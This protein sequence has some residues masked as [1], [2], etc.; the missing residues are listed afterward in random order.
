MSKSPEPIRSHIEQLSTFVTRA[1]QLPKRAC[2]KFLASYEGGFTLE[3]GEGKPT[4]L[5]NLVKPDEETFRSY[6]LDFR[7]F[8]SNKEDIFVHLIIKIAINRARHIAFRTQLIEMKEQWNEAKG[9]LH[10]AGRKN[11]DG[12][13]TEYNGEDLFLK[14]LN[15]FIF[16]VDYDAELFFNNWGMLLDTYEVEASKY[17]GWCS[18]FIIRLANTINWGL[19]TNMFDLD[20]E[21]TPH[22]KPKAKLSVEDAKKEMVIGFWEGTKQFAQILAI[23]EEHDQDPIIHVDDYEKGKDDITN[24]TVE[25]R[26]CCD[27]AVQ[28]A[29]AKIEHVT[30]YIE[31]VEKHGMPDPGFVDIIEVKITDPK[32]IQYLK[33]ALG[34]YKQKWRKAIGNMRCST[35][36]LPPGA[37]AF[38]EDTFNQTSPIVP[39]TAVYLQGCC[40][41]FLMQSL[42]NLIIW[43]DTHP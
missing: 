22:N 19:N 39:N 36:R 33:I 2:F 42:A 15:G 43:I 32:S 7:P 31:Y 21:H 5:K 24:V 25:I 37:R 8:V 23:C 6:L 29:L 20:N 30:R 35:H 10:G 17:I 16:H 27:T 26:G 28:N 4:V 1:K 11:L 12:T 9:L 38:G 13:L 14:W 3:G 41:S 18:N 34:N 40:E